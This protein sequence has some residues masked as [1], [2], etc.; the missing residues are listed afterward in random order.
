LAAVYEG[1]WPAARDDLV[2]LAVL[3]NSTTNETLVISH[4][5]RIA[6]FQIG[7]SAVWDALQ[8]DGWSEPDL[9]AIQAAYERI[10]LFG[11]LVSSLEMERAM[12]AFE[13]ERATAG[14]ATTLFNTFGLNTD[15]ELPSSIPENLDDLFVEPWH[16]IVAIFNRFVYAPVWKF[17][18]KDQDKLHLIRYW[19]AIIESTREVSMHGTRI[20]KPDRA[21][22]HSPIHIDLQRSSEDASPSFYDRIRLLMSSMLEGFGERTLQRTLDVEAA[23]NLAITAIA[24]RRYELA[25]RRLPPT[26]NELV[27]RFLVKL[28]IDPFDGESLRYRAASESEFVLYSIGANGVDDGGSPIPKDPESRA[29]FLNG[30]DIV[31][32]RPASGCEIDALK[33]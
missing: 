17:A 29:Q 24:I 30:R 3:A 12:G 25:H 26:L 10:N 23:R 31:W 9:A 19:Q 32:P 21:A 33:N 5:V 22:D 13:I 20:T 18:W 2:A 16:N 15:V 8:A 1:N 7:V 4:L 28:P 6:I 11:P 27:P 14:D